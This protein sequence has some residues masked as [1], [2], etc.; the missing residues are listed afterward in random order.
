M[1]KLTQMLK[2]K[3]KMSYGSAQFEV[4]EYFT[5]WIINSLEHS[6]VY[7]FTKNQMSLYWIGCF[8]YKL[9]QK[10]QYF[11]LCISEKGFSYNFP[12]A[13]EEMEKI[14]NFFEDTTFD[15]ANQR[16]PQQRAKI[17]F[18]VSMKSEIGFLLWF[19]F[20]CNLLLFCNSFFIAE[21]NTVSSVEDTV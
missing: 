18:I 3:K 14:D 1:W 21:L 6:Q 8:F 11:P 15:Q 2:I 13:M 12:S 19:S 5:S 9:T 16:F 10:K 20:V 17:N 7:A 4:S